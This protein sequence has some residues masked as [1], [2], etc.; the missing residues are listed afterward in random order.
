MTIGSKIS[1][2]SA[3][4]SF[5]AVRNLNVSSKFIHSDLK[6]LISEKHH[7]RKEES[8]SKSVERSYDKFS[9]PAQES[10]PISG[11]KSKPGYYDNVEDPTEHSFLSRLGE[12]N[13]EAK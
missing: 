5:N 11:S 10:L 4:R 3:E 2:R 6:D 13:R 7:K 1:K 8:Q 9:R 12:N